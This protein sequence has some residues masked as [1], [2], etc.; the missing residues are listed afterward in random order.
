MNRRSHGHD[1]A[2]GFIPSI[3]DASRFISY[4]HHEGNGVDLDQAPGGLPPASFDY[5]T[6]VGQREGEC[7]QF[8]PM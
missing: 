4:Y 5:L 6:P 8:R 2:L 7:R 1:Q 3:A